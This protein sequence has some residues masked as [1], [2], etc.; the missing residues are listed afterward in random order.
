MFG[1]VTLGCL[2]LVPPGWSLGW[3]VIQI[4]F[5]A[6]LLWGLLDLARKVRD[7]RTGIAIALTLTAFGT[8]FTRAVDYAR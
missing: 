7:G 4:V 8:L 6:A 3:A 5:F 1:A 2:A